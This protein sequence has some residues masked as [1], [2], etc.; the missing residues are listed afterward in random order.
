MVGSI[1]DKISRLTRRRQMKV[2]LGIA[3]VVFWLGLFF[4]VPMVIMLVHSF[5]KV[6]RFQIITAFTLE[7]YVDIFTSPLHVG[8]FFLSLRIALAT[9]VVCALI[10]YPFAY[11]L[12]KRAGRFKML[13]MVA[14]I[15]PFWTSFIL[16]SYAWKLLLGNQGIINSTLIFL[17]LRQ[18]PIRAFLY[19][20]MATAIGLIYVFLPDMVL[21][22]FTSLE[23]ISDSLL[24]AA[25]DLGARPWRAFWE[26]TFP[27][28]LPGLAVG[29][30]FVFIFALGEFIIP[31]L[32][33]G[34][35]S[36]L[37]SQAIVLEFVTKADWA[38][39]SAMAMVLMV[40]TLTLLGITARRVK[41]ENI[42]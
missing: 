12:A 35:K 13:G 33:G 24:Q 38:K 16:R 31:R 34:G 28:A 14:V 9:V 39:G 42:F 7:N 37:V 20:P 6:E 17:G 11:F 10:A 1:A 23:R 26:V 3:P 5:W 18:E 19:S 27:L 8:A 4:A 22:L 40:V 41:L 2:G 29:S 30:V 25:A 32:L 21:P 36:L 15:I